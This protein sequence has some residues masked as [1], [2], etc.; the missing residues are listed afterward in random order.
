MLGRKL[1]SLILHSPELACSNFQ[2]LGMAELLLSRPV[3]KLQI[4]LELRILL[5]KTRKR[6]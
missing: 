1:V 6:F 5:R 2:Q 3:L 4:A